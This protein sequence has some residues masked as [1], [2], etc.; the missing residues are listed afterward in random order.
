MSELVVYQIAQG[1]AAV[2]AVAL[3][4]WVGRLKEA[5]LVKVEPLPRN[6]IAGAVLG[7]VALL[8]CIPHA[9]PIAFEWM[10][11][12]LL[13]IAIGGAIAGY[14]FMDYL[15]SRAIGGLFIL[16]AYYFVHGAFEFHTPGMAVI[17][18]LYWILGIIGIC[19]SGKPCWMRDLLRKCCAD[20]KY[21]IGL[22]VYFAVLGVAT[23]A[24]LI[25]EK[26]N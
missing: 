12:W 9:R 5:S 3:A 8:W 6:R 1:C 23:L 7:L 11:P 18:I 17:S 22:A 20:R 2:I 10:Q 4:V 25:L 26:G 24:G 19:F 16:I 21:R 14:F 13:W 15:L